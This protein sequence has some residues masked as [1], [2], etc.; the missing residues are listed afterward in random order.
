M[1]INIYIYINIYTKRDPTNM[2]IYISNMYVYVCIK[3]V[4]IYIHIKLGL[5]NHFYF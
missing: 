2:Y 3:Y 4:C 1:N 5:T